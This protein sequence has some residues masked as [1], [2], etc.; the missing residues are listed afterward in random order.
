MP[1]AVLVS[2][3]RSKLLRPSLNSYYEV[4]IPLS[5]GGDRMPFASSLF[6]TN[7]KV[8]D[9]NLMCYD[10][11]LP[12][13]Y[14]TT[15]EVNNDF[16][17]VTER[18][19]YR[20]MYD[21]RIDLTFYVDAKNYLPIKFFESWM[22]YISGEDTRPEDGPLPNPKMANYSYRMS[23]PST[24]R[25]DGLKVIKFERD[26]TKVA[27]PKILEYEF[28]KA[29]PISINS[30][31]VSYESSDILKCTVSM[32]YLR[33]TLSEVTGKLVHDRD[34]TVN[35]FMAEERARQAPKPTLP[36]S[37]KGTDTAGLIAETADQH[38][39]TMP[40]G[41][42]NISTGPNAAK[43]KVE[44]QIHLDTAQ[45]GNTFPPNSMG[46]TRKKKGWFGWW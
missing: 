25:A 3:I 34:H 27:G 8:D 7:T 23:Y 20:R 44:A 38:N 29:F 10:A 46:A 14:F 18:F 1:R 30:M 17:G 16:T 35:D 42:M 32:T 4:K 31:P 28:I 22:A 2:E 37:M 5:A 21:D 12:G 13:S 19:A 41:A 24:Y 6:K 43:R 45:Y 9:L 36:D 11:V 26:Y 39:N 33:Y 40:E 15:S